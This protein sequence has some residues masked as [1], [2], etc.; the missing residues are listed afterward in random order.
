MYRKGTYRLHQGGPSVTIKGG[1]TMN[2]SAYVLGVDVSKTDLEVCLMQTE[3]EH[4]IR[5]RSIPNLQKEID[6]FF[7]SL[8]PEYTA[9]LCV[10]V[11]PTGPYWYALADTALSKQCKVVS[12]PTKATKQF[13][14]SLSERAK[15]DRIDARGIARYACHMKLHDYKPKDPAIR[16]LEE[17]LAMR[18]KLSQTIAEFTQ[19][20]EWMPAVA[21]LLTNTLH[22]LKEQL[23]ELDARIKE[24]EKSIGSSKRLQGVPGFGAVVAGALLTKLMSIDFASSD[25]FVAYVGLDIKVRDSGRYKGQRRLSHNGDPELRRLL[26]LAALASIRVKGSPFSKIYENHRA[27]GLSTTESLCA[28]ARKLARTAWSI[29]R[30]NVEYD[31]GRVSKDL[32]AEQ[33]RNGVT[34]P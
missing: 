34:L 26:Y 22:S 18:K 3:D 2:N 19:S 30:Y 8:S 9:S 6:A 33:S 28:V 17:L 21:D 27:R 1:Y 29:V 23:S 12:A 4:I 25:S 31:P 32:R 15:N 7:C 24:A 13:L 20:R 16:Q 10:A 11:E 14:L 5:R